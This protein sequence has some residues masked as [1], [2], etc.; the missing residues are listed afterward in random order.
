MSNTELSSTL[1]KMH[2]EEDETLFSS[3]SEESCASSSSCTS[4]TTNLICELNNQINSYRTQRN[5]LSLLLF[6]VMILYY[7]YVLLDN[8]KCLPF[9]V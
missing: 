8:Q 2:L 1:L 3:D 6:Y 9:T 5:L 4:S 7:T